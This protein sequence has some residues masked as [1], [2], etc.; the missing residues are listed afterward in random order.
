VRYY[1]DGLCSWCE[2]G[3][4][5]G[6]EKPSVGAW[7]SP[8]PWNN[9]GAKSYYEGVW[10][11]LEEKPWTK[12][13]FGSQHPRIGVDIGGWENTSAV[14]DAAGAVKYVRSGYTHWNTDAK[15]A[16]L[17]SNHL[18]LIP[19]FGNCSGCTVASFDNEAF[20]G[21]IVAWCSHYCHEVGSY[22]SG[23]EDLG[24]RSIELINEPGNPFFHSDAQTT[25]GQKA[26][27]DLTKKARAALESAFG[28]K[29]PAVMVSY[30]GGYN[31][32]AYGEA[33]FADGAVADEVTVHPYGGHVERAK[34]AEGNRAR[35]TE[36]H[37]KTGLP[38][39]VTEVGWPTCGETGDSL[40]WT[41]A[42]QA[43]NI[44]HFGEWVD[45]LGYVSYYVN[46]NFAD[47]E[48]NCY[49]IVNPSD[50]KHKQAYAAL[51]EV[52]LKY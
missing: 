34:S 4:S 1:Y 26:Y 42:E 7:F 33:I 3:Y 49:G 40:N 9:S 13:S 47:Y 22:W 48:G 8:S 12:E 14:E 16:L 37:S 31:G 46:F 10:K 38:V 32:S 29:R 30:D 27:A 51:H 25:A 50:T 18:T 17:A 6:Q 11:I 45:L 52:S 15:M 41:E 44:T 23:K 21:E 20:V 5:A 43:E 35:V 36:A 28:S 24:A 39:A 2:P 19:L